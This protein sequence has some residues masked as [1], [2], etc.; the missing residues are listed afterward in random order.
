MTA[1]YGLLRVR[2]VV[3]FIYVSLD[4]D[5]PIVFIGHGLGGILVVQVR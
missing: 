4:Q 2:K 3:I 1:G 5:R